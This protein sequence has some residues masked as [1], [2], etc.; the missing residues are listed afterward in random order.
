LVL[1]R[2]SGIAWLA[3]NKLRFVFFIYTSCYRLYKV[4]G[5][6]NDNSEFADDCL[7][8]YAHHV[9]GKSAGKLYTVGRHSKSNNTLY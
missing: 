5:S 8:F 4:Q 2:F 1:F 7:L 3:Y 9:E 6:S